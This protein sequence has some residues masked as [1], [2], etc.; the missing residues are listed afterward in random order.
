LRKARSA[1]LLDLLIGGRGRPQVQVDGD[2]AAKIPDVGQRLAQGPGL[3]GADERRRCEPPPGCGAVRSRP[4]A[5]GGS[6]TVATAFASPS[7]G[8]RAPSEKF[9]E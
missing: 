4:P 8:G 9:R 5:G 3:V 1:I 2:E 7:A 6:A